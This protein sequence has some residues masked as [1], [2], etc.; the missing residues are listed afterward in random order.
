MKQAMGMLL[1]GRRVDAEE[2]KALGFVNDVVPEGEALTAAKRWAAQILECAP[3]SVRGS[4][5]AAM[6]G[7]AA[8]SL[9]AAI[10]GRYSQIKAMYDSED[11]IEGPQA[12]SEKRA[13]QWKGQ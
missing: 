13:P 5:E 2:G 4:K 3:L 9:E 11:F 12:F 6:Q 10:K 1:T 7:L 8:D